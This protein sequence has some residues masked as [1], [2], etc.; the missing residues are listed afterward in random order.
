MV[1][2]MTKKKQKLMPFFKYIVFTMIIIS[3]ITLGL[4]KFID[5][6]PGE[7]F[8]IL[9]IFLG[10][11]NIVLSL[12][13]LAKK[14]VKKRVIGTIFSI[15]YII[16]LV[17]IIIYELNTI[18]FLKKIGF[19]NYKTENYSILVLKN[20]NYDKINDLDKKNIGS[21]A[22]TNEGLKIATEK[23]NK[24]IESKFQFYD[25][26]EDLKIAFINKD[27]DAMVIEDSILNIIIEN[28]GEF[29]NSY[30]SIYKFSLDVE[31][32]DIANEVNITNTPFNIY[33]SGIDT[34]GTVSSVA[35]SDVNMVITVNPNNHKILIT[36]IP[37]DYYV[38]LY[39]TDSKDKLT[40]AGIYGVES[41]VKTIENLL[42]I[43][44]NYYV[45]VNFSSVIKVVDALNG[46]NV[47]SKHKFISQDGYSYNVGYNYVDGEKALSFVRERKSFI[48]GDRVRVEN[49]AALIKALIDKAIS[50]SIITNYSSLLNALSD[51]FITNLDTNSITEFIKMQV[52]EMPSWEIENYSLDGTDAYEPTYSFGSTKL[53]VMN[54]DID[55][56][57]N[58]KNKINALYTN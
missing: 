37:R 5:I 57:I 29:S 19:K 51:L 28:D 41:S 22:L 50:P 24:K 30:K 17:L 35:R 9:I 6:L 21:L 34:Y 7:Y 46:V 38:K 16:I 52:S 45:K 32:E 11:M 18:G 36:S 40:H 23:I 12:L 56:V 33:I 26:I 27:L 55:T 20:S 10:L 13:I 49:Q 8:L 44:I 58:A 48:G 31:T 15:I 4:F 2:L 53:Y 54:P 14:S 43:N 25:K 42:D 1:N 39:N 3:I 47:Y